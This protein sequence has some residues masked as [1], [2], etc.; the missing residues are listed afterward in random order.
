M[1]LRL[2]EFLKQSYHG[3]DG[4]NN[5]KRQVQQKIGGKLLDV[6][7]VQ[8]NQMFGTLCGVWKCESHDLRQT[9]NPFE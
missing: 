1:G 6:K 3:F 4:G 8:K 7:K 5:L 2:R 9:K